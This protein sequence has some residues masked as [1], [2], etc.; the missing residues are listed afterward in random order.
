LLDWGDGTTSG[1]IRPFDSGVNGSASHTWTRGSYQIKAKA[2]DIHG[3][4]SDWSPSLP[5]SMPMEL[6]QQSAQS[7]EISLIQLIKNNVLK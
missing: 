2:K 6:L 1:W 7:Q 3:V 5:I 4:E